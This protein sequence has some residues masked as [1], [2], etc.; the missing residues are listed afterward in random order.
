[1][2]PRL[3]PL[4]LV[5]LLLL[6]LPVQASA[7]HVTILTDSQSKIS[8]GTLGEFFWDESRSLDIQDIVQPVYQAQ[9]FHQ[10]DP[11]PTF[12]YQ[13]KTLW[14]K[15]IIKNR[16]NKERLRYLEIDYPTLDTVELYQRNNKGDWDSKLAG[17]NHPYGQG[18][19]ELATIVFKIIV[20]PQANKTIYLKV[21]TSS[22]YVFPI[23][24]MT[25][26]GHIKNIQHRRLLVGGF[27][28]VLFVMLLYSLIIFAIARDLSHLY[29]G[30]FILSI[31]LFVFTLKGLASLVIW[32]PLGILSDRGL[33]FTITA[34]VLT[35]I[36]FTKEFLT[37][38]EQSP[39]LNR[40]ANAC[41]LF[42]LVY[43]VITQWNPYLTARLA[44]A[45]LFLLAP[46]PFLASILV[47]KRGYRPAV[48][49]LVAVF[50]T[51]LG[52]LVVA[53]RSAG[54]V[55]Y[56]IMSNNAIFFGTV[57]HI[58]VLALAL[59]DR[60]RLLAKEKEEVQTRAFELEIS[61]KKKLE[62]MVAERTKE[63]ESAQQE[64]EKANRAKSHFLASMSHEIRTPMNAIIGFSELIQ[65]ETENP[66]THSFLTHIRSSG[67]TLISLI[68]DILD[69]SKIE[70]GKFS[71][72]LE[73]VDMRQT[74]EDVRFMFSTSAYD[75]GLGFNLVVDDDM[76]ERVL[77]DETRIKQVLT[78]LCANA[79]KFTKEGEISLGLN[80]AF[81]TPDSATLNIK[82]KDTGIGIPEEQRQAV[83]EEFEQQ[84]DQKFSDFGGTG[85]GL[86]IS[87][88][89]I[90]L[91]GGSIRVND[92]IPH[93]SIFEIELPNVPVESPTAIENKN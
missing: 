76:P 29:Y 65:M 90:E 4:L 88:K 58:L 42:I 2:H 52:P 15:L 91:M 79:L 62:K 11:L 18:R 1:M 55:P 64:A 41:L 39:R 37:L 83:F 82:V 93:G 25:V 12:G 14:Y 69:I 61:A 34:V 6:L 26:E 43:F 35:V 51:I 10:D 56:G 85:L 92:N 3:Q 32:V 9:F 50:G 40:M 49:Y 33:S 66:E 22:S 70:S 36:L 20:A 84:Q 44:A 27:L 8:L 23:S 5:A 80:V 53:L 59:G 21:D 75:K 47:I 81:S 89:L 68:D 48:F 87:K 63:L 13:D 60:Y 31:G 46:L 73:P 28:G 77:L 17:D 67:Q 54:F 38:K 19:E 57:W 30:C 24:L 16:S 7:D 86:S 45:I 71:L 78:N 72:E 74:M